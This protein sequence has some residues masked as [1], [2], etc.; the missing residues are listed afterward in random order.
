MVKLSR[1]VPRVK[2]LAKFI[3]GRPCLKFV[4]GERAGVF[5][6]RRHSNCTYILHFI[7]TLYTIPC[8]DKLFY[9]YIPKC[10]TIACLM[11]LWMILDMHVM[12]TDLFD[13][14]LQGVNIVAIHILAKHPLCLGYCEFP[15]NLI[16]QLLKSFNISV[17]DMITI[18]IIFIHVMSKK[19]WHYSETVFKAFNTKATKSSL[20]W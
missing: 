8:Y 19:C 10:T 13:P 16:F 1:D 17:N 2:I 7:I 6:E 20:L 14:T 4:H 12:D 11:Y 5:S 9:K 15:D 18:K 3:Y